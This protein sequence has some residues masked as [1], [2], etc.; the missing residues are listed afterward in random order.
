M[1][2]N[3]GLGIFYLPQS[4]SQIDRIGLFAII[5]E[6]QWLINS[7]IDTFLVTYAP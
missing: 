4:Y 1:E 7:V 5:L 3:V 6:M 2:K